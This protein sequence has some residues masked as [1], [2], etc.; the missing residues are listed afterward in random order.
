MMRI[1]WYR[2]ILMIILIG[3][4]ILG[5]GYSVNEMQKEFSKQEVSSD[6]LARPSQPEL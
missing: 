2:R 4:V 3:S 5:T 1:Y 6:T